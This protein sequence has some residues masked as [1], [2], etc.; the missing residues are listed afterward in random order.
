MTEEIVPDAMLES[1]D[2]LILRHVL[3]GI[4]ELGPAL[5]VSP[6]RLAFPLDA[7]PEVLNPSRTFIRPLEV[8]QKRVLQIFPLVNAVHWQAVE[9]RASRP[10]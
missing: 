10:L 6:D 4:P 5:Y 9:P 2:R 8:L 7:K 3:N 1:V